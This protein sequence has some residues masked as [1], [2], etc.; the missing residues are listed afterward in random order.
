[1]LFRS[2]NL[3]L[4][5]AVLISTNRAIRRSARA[6]EYCRKSKVGNGVPDQ[7]S[8]ME[9]RKAGAKLT[10]CMQAR[11]DGPDSWP[12]RRCRESGV[13][14]VFV[15]GGVTP[16]APD[17]AGA[18]EGS[19]SGM[20]T[21]MLLYVFLLW[22][23]ETGRLTVLTQPTCFCLLSRA[24]PRQHGGRTGGRQANVGRPLFAQIGRAHV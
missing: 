8:K 3:F 18:T 9:E 19:S 6:C 14:C 16:R 15:G 11:C 23:L 2:P 17:A 5:P 4:L 22:G 10:S 21:P 7:G 24:S 1:M 13:E 12:C 20:S